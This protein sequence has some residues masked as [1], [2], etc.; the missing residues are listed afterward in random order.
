MS[1]YTKSPLICVDFDGT[2][3]QYD[4]WK[5]VGV[6]GDP[7]PGVANA[8]ID[9]RSRG[10][11][12]CVF[13][14]RGEVDAIKEYLE[15]HCILYDYIND[16]PVMDGQNPGKPPAKYFIDDRA[17]RFEGSWTRVMRQ[18]VELDEIELTKNGAAYHVGIT[19]EPTP[20]CATE[21]CQC[22]C[23]TDIPLPRYGRGYIFVEA[24][25][26]LHEGQAV[27]IKDGKAYSVVSEPDRCWCGR[28]LVVKGLPDHFDLGS[29]CTLHYECP[30]HGQYWEKP[31]GIAISG[32]ARSGKDTVGAIFSAELGYP[33]VHFAD[34]LKRE[35]FAA[36]YTSE[37]AMGVA[38]VVEEVNQLKNEHMDVRQKLIDYGQWRRASDPFYWVK[39]IDTSIPVVVADARFRNEYDYLRERGFFMVRVSAAPEVREERGQ[40]DLDDISETELDAVTEWDAVID[41]SGTLEGLETRV[42]AVVEL[43]KGRNS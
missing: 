24:G 8:M 7:L 43:I 33:V 9:L 29:V 26:K 35:W 12:I 28:P 2:I 31:R 27:Y 21:A 42:R 11:Q 40:K 13:T 5:G 36:N 39:R 17:V 14:T 6:F 34:E 23:T 4:G 30:I 19:E 10:Y 3:A 37:Y 38:D 22:G 32:K 16:A 18:I 25:E 1:D 20:R 41:N 15:R